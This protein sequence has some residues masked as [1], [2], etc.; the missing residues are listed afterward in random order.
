MGSLVTPA[1]L[2]LMR[3]VIRTWVTRAA[4]LMVGQG[5]NAG[6]GGGVGR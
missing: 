2:P 5:N 1:T 6:T 3:R 4:L